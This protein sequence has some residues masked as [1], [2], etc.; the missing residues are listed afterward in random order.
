MLRLIKEANNYQYLS[1]CLTWNTESR[2]SSN[3]TM[4]IHSAKCKSMFHLYIEPTSIYRTD[5]S[6]YSSFCYVGK[7]KLH[8]HIIPFFSF[9]LPKSTACYTLT[10]VT[11]LETMKSME[12]SMR[13]PTSFWIVT[14]ITKNW[15]VFKAN[16][17]RLLPARETSSCLETLLVFII[18]YINVFNRLLG[19]INK[20]YVQKKRGICHT[21]LFYL[22][23]FS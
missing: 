16:R 3:C 18:L 11:D 15:Q 19:A 10:P 7:K 9:W 5:I 13:T 14:V 22:L 2:I 23:K 12:R 6:T 1:G 17:D 21:L 20:A 4:P 8:W